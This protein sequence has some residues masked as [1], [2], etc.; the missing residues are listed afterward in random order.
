MSGFRFLEGSKTHSTCCLSSCDLHLI[1]TSNL[2]PKRTKKMFSPGDTHSKC[3]G[4]AAACRNCFLSHV[5]EL[6]RPLILWIIQSLP[7]FSLPFDTQ[8]EKLRRSCVIHVAPRLRHCQHRIGRRWDWCIFMSFNRFSAK[9][10]KWM[11]AVLHQ[12]TPPT[13]YLCREPDLVDLYSAFRQHLPTKKSQRKFNCT[14]SQ[15]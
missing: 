14:P 15:G 7:C 2:S 10:Q 4:R 5:R 11:N 13:S 12:R 3:Q 1:Q 9:M 8:L 6:H